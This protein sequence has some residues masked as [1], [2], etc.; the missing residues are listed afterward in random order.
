MLT[1]I[2]RAVLLGAA[3]TTLTGAG[4]WWLLRTAVSWWPGSG[5]VPPE[6]GL[7]FLAAGTAGI[8]AGWAAGVLGAATVSLAREGSGTTA[9]GYAPRGHGRGTSPAR[10]GH[11]AGLR[12]RVAAGLLVVAGF[13]AAAP[14]TA[15][16]LHA[17]V[18][19][20]VP[21]LAE[22][23]G[24]ACGTDGDGVGATAL[25]RPGW[26][27]TVLERRPARTAAAEVGLVSTAAA[28]APGPDVEEVV[29]RRGDTLW[30]ISARHL[31]PQATAQDVAESWPRW[32]AANRDVIGEDPH[33]IRPGQRLVAPTA[34]GTR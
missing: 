24:A 25:P 30:D 28:P 20:G 2:T 22:A 23:D 3:A 26:T 19:V 12:G 7:A 17:T 32:Y 6:A 29:V 18:S 4:A 15:V 5:V 27:P 1:R 31:G 33:L 13:G 34:G 16:D 9:A 8:L 10:G 11:A 14:A 21:A